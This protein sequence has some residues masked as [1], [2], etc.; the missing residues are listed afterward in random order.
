MMNILKNFLGKIF[1]IYLV[2]FPLIIYNLTIMPTYFIDT[3]AH[4]I[5]ERLKGRE[6][7]VVQS[8]VDAG[9]K[10]IITVGC[11]IE[12]SKESL[13]C[14]EKF[15]HVY[16]S[17]GVHPCD[18][19]KSV[20]WNIF[21]KILQHEKCKAIGESGMDFHYTQETESLQKEYFI[22]QIHLSN[23]YNKPLII[24]TRSAKEATLEILKKYK[25]NK[26][27][28]HCFSEDADF[29]KEIIK[30]GG[31]ISFGG[32]ITYPKADIIRNAL[33]IIPIENIMLETDCPYLAPQSVRGK[34][35]EP[36]YIPEIALKVSEIKNIS[37]DEV[38]RI[39]TKNAEQFFGI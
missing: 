6:K 23:T 5:W 39:T 37:L 24:H 1:E 27:V 20:D 29:A 34:V 2:K 31:M 22:K 8:A 38:A 15:E 35:N 9:V 33:S 14:A 7:E 32:I 12:T 19:K 30:L 3:H 26:F 18:V 28:V 36:K 4:I 16:F 10:K 11:D 25:V 21:E 13:L 17:T